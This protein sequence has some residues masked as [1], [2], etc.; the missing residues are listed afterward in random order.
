MEIEI[1]T[2]IECKISH[3]LANIIKPCI[4]YKEVYYT[5]G[6]YRKERREFDKPMITKGKDCSYFP[7]GLLSRVLAFC[8]EKNI[9][10][11]VKGKLDRLPFGDPSLKTITLREEQLR[12]IKKATRAHRGVLVAFTGVGKT[13]IGMGVISSF[14]ASNKDLTVLWLCHTKDLMYQSADVAK[15]ELGVRVGFIGDGKSH[16]TNNFTFATRQSF[17]KVASSIGLDFDVVVVDETHHLSNQYTELLK[18]VYAPVRIGLTATMPTDM[19]AILHI[20]GSLGPIIDTVSIEEGKERGIMA[21]IK[22]KFIKVPIDHK[23]KELRSYQDVYKYGVV[24]KQIRHQMIIEKAKYHVDKN[25]SVLIIVNRIEHG[26]RLLLEAQRQGLECV[27]ARGATEA[28][29]RTE[30][31]DA[32]NSKDIHCAIATTIWKEGINLPELNVIINAA[33]GRSEISTLQTI[34][35]GLRLTE[36]KKQLIMY[37]IMDL[38]NRYLVEHLAERLALYSTNEWI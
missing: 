17:I 10:V 7:T 30:I 23:V 21:D 15:K 22:I 32:L 12:Q 5:Q 34:G 29:A 37:D 25:D 3:A 19:K 2:P 6:L 8:K 26:E 4:S 31:R 16:L 13:V 28:T 38:S 33:G 18:Y 36:T 14:L 20:E 11:K 27:F 1:Y 24:E 35:R 9:P